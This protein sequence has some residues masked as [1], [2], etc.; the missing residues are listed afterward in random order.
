VHDFLST[1]SAG[2]P[3]KPDLLGGVSSA[4][5]WVDSAAQGWAATTGQERPTFA[6]TEPDCAVL[7]EF[8]SALLA[9]L[10]DRSEPPTGDQN[11]RRP[12]TRAGAK[13]DVELGADGIVRMVAR[14][15]GWRAVV[16]WVLSEVYRAQQSGEW[17]RL[18]ACRNDRCRGVFYDRSRNNSGVWH[19]VRTCGNALNLR[20]SR[21]R[22]KQQQM[23]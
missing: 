5:R 8:R 14:G 15:A 19:N 3:R 2:R 6:L 22:R 17:S 7:R 9:T 4:Q 13:L 11:P 23:L 20:A 10:I 16:A 12:W 18:K 1:A 21:A